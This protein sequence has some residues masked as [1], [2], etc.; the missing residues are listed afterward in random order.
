M[1]DYEG[2]ADG[3]FSGERL[4]ADGHPL[5]EVQYIEAKIIL[6]GLR[7]TS[8][9]SFRE[10]AKI[11]KRTAKHTHIDF[12]TEPCEGLR[13]QIREV[14]FLDTKDFALYNNAFILRR[15]T[16]YEDGFPVGHPE[17]VFKFRH[18]DLDTASTLDVRPAIPG[19]YRIKF[20]EEWL[21]RKDRI[22]GVR[23]LF[24]HNVEFKLDPLHF[25]DD[26]R[27]SET[28][29]EIFPSLQPLLASKKQHLQLVNHTAVEEVLQQL[30][31][32]DF[33]K[34][35]EAASNVS[36][37]RTRGDHRQLVGEFSFQ[38]KFQRRGAVS[39]KAL[40]KCTEFFSMLQHEAQDWVNLGVTKTAAV[41]RLKGNPPQSHE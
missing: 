6:N 34:G 30:G 8:V 9:Q 28:L 38:S 2:D 19:D 35:F 23:S 21:P 25:G 12:E 20:K 17:I 7:F 40:E 1:A 4:Y 41:Y 39:A 18:P 33:G 15:R 14:L 27:S 16:A 11:V 3:N 37:W 32:L 24:S 29:A 26:L 36:V 5:D 10:F 22:G 13:P 31:T